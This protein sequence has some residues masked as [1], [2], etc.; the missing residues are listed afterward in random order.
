MGMVLGRVAGEL[1]RDQSAFRRP[2]ML[3]SSPPHGSLTFRVR[4]WRIYLDSRRESRFCCPAS[5]GCSS[6]PLRQ[7]SVSPSVGPQST[8]RNTWQIGLSG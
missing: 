1:G 6:S 4:L 3:M 7:V 2:G 5:V 8:V